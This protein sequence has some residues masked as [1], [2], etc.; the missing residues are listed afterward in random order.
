VINGRCQVNVSLSSRKYDDV[1]APPQSVV[2]P[3][4]VA[5]KPVVP[6]PSASFLER[7]Y[8]DVRDRD[9]AF[10][11]NNPDLESTSEITVERAHKLVLNQWPYFNHMF[12]SDFME[13]GAGE[14]EI[15]VKDVKPQVFQLL[16]RFMYTGVIPQGE[17]PTVTFSDSLTNPQE[18]S[19][20][21]VFLAAHRYELDELCELAQKQILE[22]LTSQA[23]IPF[24]FRTGYLFD[25]FRAPSIKYIASTNAGQVAS[26]SFRDT[27]QD[28]PEFGGLVFELF[29]ECHGKK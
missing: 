16:L 23:T 8:N 7:L 9:V 27:Y 5:P 15:Q 24:L 1:P 2:A 28:H 21:D 10:I 22:K 20:E 18:A 14:K 3:E 6:S 25:S 11:F 13:G 29:E 12:R 17:Q 19:W 4:P 26:K